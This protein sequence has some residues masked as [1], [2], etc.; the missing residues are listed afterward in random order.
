MFKKLS[1]V[2]YAIPLYV[3]ALVQ[4]KTMNQQLTSK[5]QPTNKMFQEIIK[6]RKL[7]QSNGYL[8]YRQYA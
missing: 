6:I 8:N 7:K 3:G 1:F 4:N 5:S 2:K